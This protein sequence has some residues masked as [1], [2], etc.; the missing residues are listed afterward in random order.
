[1]GQ[2]RVYSRMG[3]VVRDDMQVKKLS[4]QL[5]EH[6]V[7]LDTYVYPTKRRKMRRLYFYELWRP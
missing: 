4:L 2:T 3:I 1:M 6:A 7:G 5:F